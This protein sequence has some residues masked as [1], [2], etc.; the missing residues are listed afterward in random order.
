MNT[1]ETIIKTHNP[2]KI[3]PLNGNAPRVLKMARRLNTK[4]WIAAGTLLGLYRDGDFIR[5]DTDIDIEVEG[6]GGV[7]SDTINT[8]SDM[9]L[10]RTVHKN[11][12]PMQIAFVHLDCIF[13]VYVFWHEGDFMVN[14]NDCGKM[15]VPAR[16][17][18]DLAILRTKYGDFPCPDPLDDYLAVRYGENWETPAN[19]KGL[20]THAI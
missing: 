2:F 19:H 7:Y 11:N 14:H 4:Y 17:Y 16:F 12:K 15:Q 20:Y 8:F 18:K 10:I 9:T 3:K 6:C 13:D 1:S 5:G